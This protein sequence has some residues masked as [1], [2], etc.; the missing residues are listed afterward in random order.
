MVIP[1]PVSY[2]EKRDQH[3]YITTL[4]YQQKKL[5]QS[6]QAPYDLQDAR[7]GSYEVVIV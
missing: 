1:N 6:M 4:R 3:D 7:P 2:F 5:R